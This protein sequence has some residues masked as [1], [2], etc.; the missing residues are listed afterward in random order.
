MR[1]FTRSASRGGV[2]ADFDGVAWYEEYPTRTRPSLVLNGYMFS[3]LGLY[4]VAPWSRTAARLYRVGIR[5]LSARIARFDRPGGSWYMPGV[6]A[7]N[8]YH[9]V[10]VLQLTA[11]D[12]VTPSRTLKR[13]RDR[14]WLAVVD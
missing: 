2:R 3:L 6:P 14:W 8:Y 1:P 5:T 11:L 13:Y 10:H 7:S 4:D 9:A 12:S